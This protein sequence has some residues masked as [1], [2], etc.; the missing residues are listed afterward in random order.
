[1]GPC[2]GGDLGRNMTSARAKEDRN[3][4]ETRT[5]RARLEVRGDPA[6]KNHIER[7]ERGGG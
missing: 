7:E 1:V 5:K 6:G 4:M 3:G 2:F